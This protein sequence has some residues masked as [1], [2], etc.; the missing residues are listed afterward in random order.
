MGGHAQLCNPRHRRSK[1]SPVVLPKNLEHGERREL[2]QL[3]KKTPS[4]L[5]EAPRSAGSL[6]RRKRFIS[7]LPDNLQD[8]VLTCKVMRRVAAERDDAHRIWSG[9]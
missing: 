9:Y 8:I 5:L 7:A 6:V 4:R 1:I 2:R 3:I